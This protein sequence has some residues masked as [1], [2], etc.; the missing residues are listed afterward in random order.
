M[1]TRSNKQPEQESDII[2]GRNA[3][4]EAL[5]ASEPLE[6][7]YVMQGRDDHAIGRITAVAKTCGVHVAIVPREKFSKLLQGLG[8][9]VAHQGVV[10]MRSAAAEMQLEDIFDRAASRNEKPFIVLLDEIMD[11]HNVGAIIRTAECAGAHGVIVLRHHS[12]PIGST[13]AKTSAGAVFHI[14][15]VK[16]SNLAQTIEAL[17]QKNIWIVGAAGEGTKSYT[18]FDYTMPIGIVVGS[19]GTGLRA[20][21]KKSCDEIVR[22]PLRGKIESLNASVAAGVLLYEV[23]RQRG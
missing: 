12:A 14:P 6:R 16:I 23:V 19:E 18:E 15:I 11:P 2:F 5:R 17:K 20:L 13:V 8:E 1:T 4:L 22:I 3:V 10:A 21:V 9:D 7:V